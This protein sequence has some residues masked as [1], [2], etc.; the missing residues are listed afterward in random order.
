[1]FNLDQYVDVRHDK[2]DM[3]STNLNTSVKYECI[4]ASDDKDTAPQEL[5]N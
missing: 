3:D 1:M 5:N 4:T 2:D